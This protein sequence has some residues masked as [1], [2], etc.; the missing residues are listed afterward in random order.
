[1]SISC[2]WINSRRSKRTDESIKMVSPKDLKEL[3]RNGYIRLEDGMSKYTSDG[4]KYADHCMTVYTF[5]NEGQ[6]V[7]PVDSIGSVDLVDVVIEDS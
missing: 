7:A 5:V 1:M 4:K 3:L 6:D 2:P